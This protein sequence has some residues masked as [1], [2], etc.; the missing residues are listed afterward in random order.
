MGEDEIFWKRGLENRIT[1][2][3]APVSV[4]PLI[5]EGNATEYEFAL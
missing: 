3:F 1:R 2:K 4:T 5:K